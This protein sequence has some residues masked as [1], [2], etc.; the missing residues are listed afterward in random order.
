MFVQWTELP[1]HKVQRIQ[2][3][4][5]E[6]LEKKALFSIFPEDSLITFCPR[7]QVFLSNQLSLQYQLTDSA[8]VKLPHKPTQQQQKQNITKAQLC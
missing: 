2:L 4:H 3:T 5:L 1:D 7:Q 8:V 6:E